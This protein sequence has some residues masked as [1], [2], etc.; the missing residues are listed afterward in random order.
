MACSCIKY[1][2]GRGNSEVEAN[3][4]EILFVICALY[5]KQKGRTITHGEGIIN[6]TDTRFQLDFLMQEPL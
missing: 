5:I 6:I 1:K 2:L 4:K 3:V